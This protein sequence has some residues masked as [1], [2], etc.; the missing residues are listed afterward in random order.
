MKEWCR[1]RILFTLKHVEVN[2]TT[3]NITL[4][5]LKC[6]ATYGGVRLKN[7]FNDGYALVLMEILCSRDI[8][9]R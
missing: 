3:N 8:R 1:F 5:L 9:L 6:M 7:L 4:I 2:A